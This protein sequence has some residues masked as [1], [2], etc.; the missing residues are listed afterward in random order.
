MALH[1]GVMTAVMALSHHAN[2]PK[3]PVYN[4]DFVGPTTLASSPAGGASKP[5]EAAAPAPPDKSKPLPQISEFSTRKDK[6]H[7]PLPKPSLLKGLLGRKPRP[8]AEE[9][10]SP[11]PA[12]L[13]E[14]GAPGSAGIATD[15]PNFPYPW[16][17][18]QIRSRLW[19]QWSDNMPATSG[20]AV[21][22]FTLMPQGQMVDLKIE[23]SSGDSGFDLAALACAQDAGPYPPLPE[24]FGEPFLKI[25]VTL[26]GGRP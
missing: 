18:S 15:M 12:R 2:A 23:T 7:G 24:G 9:S 6:R 14:A 11:G 3:S 26:A 22:V 1:A 16:Y 19:N 10:P 13:E 4:I 25:H 20:E 17:I 5:G 21:V 8:Q